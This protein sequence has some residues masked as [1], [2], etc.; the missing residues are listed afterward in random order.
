[1]SQKRFSRERGFQPLNGGADSQNPRDVTIDI[2]LNTV[3]SRG[4]TGARKGTLSPTLW[5]SKE[6]AQDSPNEKTGFFSRGRAPG[7]RRKKVEEK[8][9]QATDPEDGT[10]T[11]MGQIYEKILNFSVITRYF[12]Y[13]SPLAL[14]IAIPIIIGA[15]A[16]QG[17]EIAGVRIVWFFSWIE[18]VWLSLWVSKLIARFL[19]WLFTFLVGIVSPG[20]RKYA[21]VLKSLEIPLSLVGWA[22]TSLA[23]FVPIM[24]LNPD[25]T[26]DF[27]KQLKTDPTASRTKSWEVTVRSILWAA[28]FSTLVLLVEKLLV[29]LISISYHQTQFSE[30]IK[31]SKHNIHLLGL[32]Y[33]ASRALF[34]E[35][36]PEFETEDY[37]INDSLNLAKL[38]GSRTHSARKTSGSAT[39]MHMLQDVGRIGDRVISRF[40]NIAQ[41]VTGKQVF[42]PNSAHGI[43]IEALERVSSSEALARRIWM[44]L[45]MEGKDALYED[46]IHDVLGADRKE[47][48]EEAFAAIDR[49]ANGDIS[50]DEMVLTVCEL[51]RERKSIAKSIHDV[52]QAVNVLDNL[53]C[54]VVFIAVIFIFVALLNKSFTTTLATAGTAL[55]SLSFVFSVT[56]QEVLGSCIFLFVKHPFDVGDRIDIATDQLIVERISLLFTV[57]RSVKDHRTKQVANIVL[58]TVWIENITRSKAMREAINLNVAV[59]TSL[60]DIQLLKNELQNFVREKDNSRDF[61]PEVNISVMDVSDMS[62]LQLQIDLAHKSNWANEAVRATRR[63]KF[64]CALVLAVRKVPIYGPGGGGAGVGDPANPSYSVAISNEQAATN[65]K[66]FAEDKEKKRMVPTGATTAIS[67][68]KSLNSPVAAR[69]TAVDFDGNALKRVK[70]PEKTAVNTL[71]ARPSAVD[72]ARDH[73]DNY[74][75][76]ETA[77]ATAINEKQTSPSPSPDSAAAGRSNDI[78]EVRGLLH[79]ESTKG[80]RKVSSPTSPAYPQPVASPTT[81]PTIR[82][83]PSQQSSTGFT[84]LEITALPRM[85]SPP[86]RSDSRPRAASNATR[87]SPY[88]ATNPPLGPPPSAGQPRVDFHEYDFT[89]PPLKSSSRPQSPIGP[90]G[91]APSGPLPPTGPPPQAVGAVYNTNNPYSPRRDFSSE[92][93]RGPYQVANRRPVGGPGGHGQGQGSGGNGSG[94]G[95][96]RSATPTGPR[97]QS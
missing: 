19:P 72:P 23:T 7:G 3:N 28:F 59:D 16:A 39:P 80:R 89:P 91:P 43:V 5:Q 27:Q 78:E 88:N 9:R 35:Y 96:S 10:M 2:P 58:N 65:K 40:G 31:Q 17:A 51:G 32:L 11:S 57:F 26:A 6:Q 30:K 56:A 81:V 66:V 25:N 83:D 22:L 37:I 95:G 92:A 33:D 94:G 62:K 52:D 49:D 34:P 36:S 50:L 64:M 70:S 29:Q 97:T 15:T 12:L 93:Q 77:A 79:R 14:I 45:V 4:Q 85:T 42:N 24:T 74:Y 82:E 18:I 87:P 21:L 75:R 71:N 20:V 86:P 47:E 53:L 55:L 13:V 44:S 73:P 76:E 46:D 67:P 48:A 41:E 69:S 63:S 1:M 60:E 61:L 8:G 90:S 68:I 38:G 84:P 54:T